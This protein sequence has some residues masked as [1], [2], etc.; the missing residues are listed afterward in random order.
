MF[1]WLLFTDA[2]LP[3]VLWT[4]P[5]V[6]P[7][8]SRAPLRGEQGKLVLQAL[9]VLPCVRKEKQALKGKSTW[10]VLFS[11]LINMSFSVFFTFFLC[12]LQPLLE[13]ERCQNCYHASCLGPNFPK[14]NKKRK[15]WVGFLE[16]TMS[17]VFILVMPISHSKTLCRCVWRAS[18]AKV[19]ALHQER[20]GRLSGT[21][22]K[23][24][25]QTVQNSLSRVRES[26]SL[27][28]K[29]IIWWFVSTFILYRH[30]LCWG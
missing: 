6:L 19:V 27:D 26:F 1:F 22:T 17:G 21:M 4:F 12:L 16:N 18:G 28:E 10:F 2:V 3:S 7:W 5:Q 30:Y 23:D 14:Q 20:V 9:Q 29:C 13:C 8:A 11:F 15:A 24:S 25:V